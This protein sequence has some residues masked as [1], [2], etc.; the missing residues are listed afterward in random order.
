[1]T[2]VTSIS[3]IYDANLALGDVNGLAD[4]N[5]VFVAAQPSDNYDQE[6]QY[7]PLGWTTSIGFGASSTGWF[8]NRFTASAASALK[9]VSFYAA[10]PASTYAVL[11]GA[12]TSSLSEVARGTLDLAGYHT[13]DLGSSPFL[14]A[15]AKFVVAVKL[16]TPGCGYPIPAE[17]PWMSPVRILGRGHGIA[18][19]ELRQRRWIIVDRSHDHEWLQEH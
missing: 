8:A 18:R 1:M 5:A 15:G 13:V 9:A 14:S 7:D 11:E 3:R 19:P 12:S 16:T 6:Y 2:A 17:Y 4:G 10:A